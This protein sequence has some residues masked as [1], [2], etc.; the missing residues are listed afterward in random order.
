[1]ALILKRRIS[2]YVEEREAEEGKKIAKI[3]H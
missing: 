3:F 1:L 2:A